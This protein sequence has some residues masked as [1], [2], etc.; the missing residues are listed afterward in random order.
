VDAQGATERARYAAAGALGIAEGARVREEDALAREEVLSVRLRVAEEEGR[1]MDRAVREYA[2]LVRA[3]ER[4]QSLPSSPP[5]P[6]QVPPT[7]PPKES[8]AH[9]NGKYIA[10][11]GN[12]MMSTFEA[13]RE[14]KAG[15]HKL[16]EEFQGA[17]EALRA[18]NV[19]L[20]GVLEEVRA[21]LEAERKAAQEVR[22]W[23]SDARTELELLKHDDN[24]A[25]RMVSRY[26]YV[27]IN[28]P[29]YSSHLLSQ[30]ILPN[31]H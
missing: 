23:L 19:T 6:Q 5:R 11:D 17:S 14:Q 27:P 4:R 15:L 31:H 13:L 26:M 21:E 18:E 10:Q 16:A 7:P 22:T 2:D 25:A 24:A 3:L 8:L 29:L 28:P 12:G 30:E 9:S 1:M 20:Q